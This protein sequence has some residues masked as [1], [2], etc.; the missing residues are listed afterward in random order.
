MIDRMI[1]T[2]VENY[3]LDL[4]IILLQILAFPSQGGKG[5]RVEMFNPAINL[6]GW[7]VD[8]PRKVIKIDRTGLISNYSDKDHAEYLKRAIETE[9]LKTRSTLLSQV[10]WG[11]GK[12]VLGI[13]EGAVGL[14]GIIVPEP[15]TTAGGAVMLVLGSNSIVDGVS[16]LS[17]ANQGHG[18]NLLSEGFG[19]VGAGIADLADLNPEVGRNVGKGI[20]L[21]SSIAAGSLAS[22]KILR[23]PGKVAMSLRVG[24]H[25]GGVQLGRLDALYNS[26]KAKDG[27]TLL[28]INNNSGQSILRFVT[29]GG[30]LMVNGRI[31]G[32]QR[33]LSHEASA[34]EIVKGLLKLL[35]HGAKF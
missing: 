12:V 18:I 6:D 31:V 16:Q 29:H 17:G 4:S 30:R 11:T 20:F 28:S 1:S 34:K 7:E 32:V 25:P 13:V 8:H 27:M 19:H 33:V 26:S 2:F 5:Y 9:F 10:G 21:V 35:A 24:G 3:P 14:V 22:I 23:V 15:G